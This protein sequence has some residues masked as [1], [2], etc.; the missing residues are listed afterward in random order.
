MPVQP[1]LAESIDKPTALKRLD[2]DLWALQQKID[3]DRLA[4]KIENG[5]VQ[6]YNR[7]GIPYVRR[8]RML[9][10][11]TEEFTRGNAFEGKWIF[12]GEFVG[13]LY[14]TFDL[15][16]ASCDG[17]VM[18]DIDMPFRQ[19]YE[20]LTR[21]M[22]LWQPKK[23]VLAP[24]AFTAEE[25]TA[26]YDRLY[27]TDREGVIFRNMESRY[28]FGV[29]SPGV[30][31]YKFFETA[32]CIIQSIKPDGK[33]SVE[34]AM[35]DGGDIVPVGKCL[36]SGANLRTAK[37]GDV[38]EVSY[39]YFGANNRLYQPSFVRFRTDKSL[40]ECTIDSLKHVNKEVLV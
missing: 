19:R 17:N 4:V 29:R 5:K 35:L 30:Q 26:T 6:Y 38:M 18:V 16:H 31:K 39:L 11:M 33:S 14:F 25:K 37:V 1:M 34:L 36:M 40:D 7:Q 3:G 24:T 15:I 21:V 2:D 13:N 28:L 20:M 27:S 22:K 23:T 9:K 8:S 32:D 10:P 12:D